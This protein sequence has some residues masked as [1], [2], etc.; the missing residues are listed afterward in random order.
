[1]VRRRRLRWATWTQTTQRTA[2]NLRFNAVYA[3]V[4]DPDHALCRGG[5]RSSCAGL[6]ELRGGHLLMHFVFY[7]KKYGCVAVGMA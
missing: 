2:N 7:T 5:C 1:M 3:R 4:R 6:H